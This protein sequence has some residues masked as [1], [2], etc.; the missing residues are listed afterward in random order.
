MTDVTKS[1]PTSMG[2]SFS[3]NSEGSTRETGRFTKGEQGREAAI[4]AATSEAQG[5]E[6]PDGVDAAAI[7]ALR[8]AGYDVSA[9][10]NDK[11]PLSDGGDILGNIGRKPLETPETPAAEAPVA[12]E[13]QT[14]TD[15]LD[16]LKQEKVEAP[17]SD[18]PVLDTIREFSQ[19]W[20]DNGELSVD[21]RTAVK[22]RYNLDDEA[23]DFFMSAMVSHET[24]NAA[25][26]L[27]EI[28]YTVD[29]F[30]TWEKW[31]ASNEQSDVIEGRW[32]AMRSANATTRKLG[33]DAL[34]SAF[35]AANSA[36]PSMLRGAG[37][38]PS[39][40]FQAIL[41]RAMKNPLYEHNGPTADA[42]RNEINSQ[43]LA[44]KRAG[45]P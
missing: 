4:A 16:S 32:E 11:A 35:D 23:L 19:E 38:A 10:G 13:V 8:A 33:V 24:T 39:E 15:G 45:R 42:Y 5:T 14:S 6:M 21:S 40:G 9:P 37:S 26:A 25:S 2:R 12:E 1:K 7:E 31:S 43:L 34:K 41:N 3:F 44:A 27:K 28:G 22:E 30:T 36:E 29:E 18:V 20:H 17:V